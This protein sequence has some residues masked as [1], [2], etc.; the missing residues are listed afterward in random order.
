MERTQAK[1]PGSI[2]ILMVDDQRLVLIGLAKTISEMSPAYIVGTAS[3][4]E[5]GLEQVRKHR[6][7]IV[8]MDVEM[9]GM[10]GIEATRR[11]KR[12][13][14]DTKVIA[15]SVEEDYPMPRVMLEAGAIGYLSKSAQETEIR[16]AIAMACNNNEYIGKNVAQKIALHT[17][18]KW[19]RSPFA[20]LSSREIQI[21]R[22]VFNSLSV[23]TI[24]EQLALSP[25]TVNSYR[26]RIFSKLNIRSDMQL[27]LL[28]VK[29]GLLDIKQTKDLSCTQ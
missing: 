23:R 6:P 28:A 18:N 24:S 11:I 17:L 2:K 14:P 4:G 9:P 12:I 21:A 10:D 19:D 16:E 25:K 27:A 22:M 3:S 29:F 26:Y 13:A 5:E 8:F 20:I 1:A 15:L 7:N